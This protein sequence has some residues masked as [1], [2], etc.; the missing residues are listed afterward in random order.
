MPYDNPKQA[1]A[2]FL[3]IKRRQ[4]PAAAKAWA[5][6]HKGEM[7]SDKKEPKGKRGKKRGSGYKTRSKRGNP[8][9]KGA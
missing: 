6:K 3:A 8:F 9:A 5:K 7:G 1:S 4:G 2:I